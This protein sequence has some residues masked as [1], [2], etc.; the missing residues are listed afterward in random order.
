MFIGNVLV[1]AIG[2]APKG[3]PATIFDPNGTEQWRFGLSTL[4]IPVLLV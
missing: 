4:L 1:T 3:L 2:A